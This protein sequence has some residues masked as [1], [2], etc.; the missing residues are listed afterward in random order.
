MLFGIFSY[1]C[2][3][4]SHLRL[5]HLIYPSETLSMP[6]HEFV[7]R[8]PKHSMSRKLVHFCLQPEKNQSFYIAIFC[9]KGALLLRNRELPPASCGDLCNST[10]TKFNQ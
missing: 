2:Y 4:L 10:I 8:C 3:I 6:S 9:A 5:I 1:I 7:P